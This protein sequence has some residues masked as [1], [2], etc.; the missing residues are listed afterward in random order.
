MTP[1]RHKHAAVSFRD[2]AALIVGGSNDR[3]FQGR[4]RS[5]E[6]Y[7]PRSG[8]FIRVGQM[9]QARFKLPDAV[10][11]LPSGHVLVA[12]GARRA[13]LYDPA[14]R[15]VRRAGNAGPTLSFSTATVLRD[16]RV[17]VAGGY[18]DRIAVT[19][20]VAIITPP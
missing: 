14:G 5:A 18:D 10:V 4:Y 7:T 8:R 17:L 13:E 19:S 1:P 9:S 15:R 12:G 11:R 16:G 6:L 20:P 3:D 2:G